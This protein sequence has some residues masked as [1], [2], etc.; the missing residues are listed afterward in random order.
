M[1]ILLLGFWLG[2]CV[3]GIFRNILGGSPGVDCLPLDT[4]NWT[5]LRHP[6]PPKAGSRRSWGPVRP[7]MSKQVLGAGHRGQ[8]SD[9]PR[10]SPGLHCYWLM[11]AFP[12]AEVSRS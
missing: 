1:G 11:P 3:P 8:L 12:S 2:P 5:F 6:P 4:S 9:G 7:A 10:S